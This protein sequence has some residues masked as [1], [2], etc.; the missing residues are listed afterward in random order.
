VLAA[1]QV[2]H[3]GGPSMQAAVQSKPC[4]CSSSS[5]PRYSYADAHGVCLLAPSPPCCLMQLS[6]AA[7]ALC[8][9]CR[10]SCGRAQQLLVPPL[11]GP[12]CHTPAWLSTP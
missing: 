2:L 9:H 12:L 7:A 5:S 4:S 8:R 3:A 1:C 6:T 10:S 11:V